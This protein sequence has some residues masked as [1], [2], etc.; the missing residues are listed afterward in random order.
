MTDDIEDAAR[1]L[2]DQVEELGGAVAAIERGFQKAEIERSAYQVARQIDAGERVVVGVNR[3]ASADE[4]PLPAAAGGPGHRARSRRSGWPSCAA[5]R[6]DAA[7]QARLDDL[8]R[9]A[10]G[11]AERAV[12]AA[13]GAAR[14]RHRGRGLRR[15]AR[16]LGHVP[17][18]RCGLTAPA[19]GFMPGLPCHHRY[20]GTAD[21]GHRWPSAGTRHAA[22]TLGV[23]WELQ[24]IDAHTRALRQ[25][26]REVLAALPG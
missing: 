14:P 17:A 12:P 11:N 8:R 24:L 15:A 21:G 25:D 10:E 23:E 26:A 2:I 13:R 9:A 19:G 6:D 5:R 3:F 22:P 7:S 18:A 20:G 1:A 16:G 4:E